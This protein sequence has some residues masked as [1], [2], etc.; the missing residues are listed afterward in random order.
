M[1]HDII[2]QPP[3]P[4]NTHAS[5][6]SMIIQ[7]EITT[8]NSEKCDNFIENTSQTPNSS[9]GWVQINYQIDNYCPLESDN[10]CEQ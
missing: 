10:N 2:P 1:W 9:L 6:S 4:L 5:L 7:T 8:I 3:S